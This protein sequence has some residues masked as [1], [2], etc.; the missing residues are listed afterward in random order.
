MTRALGSRI[1][2]RRTASSLDAAA[3]QHAVAPDAAA[4][5]RSYLGWMAAGGGACFLLLWLWI[6]SVP[7]AYLDP[8]YSYWL[9][10]Q[11]MLDRCDLGDV[12]ILGD[13]RAA[14]GIVPAMLPFKATNLAV[15][16]G[17]PVEAY[18][19]L[20]RA[21]ACPVRP[22]RVILSFESAHFMLWDLFWE[23]AA[24]FGFVRSEDLGT[25]RSAASLSGDHS[26]YRDQ[27][28]LLVPQ[29]LR[30]WLYV[31]RFPPLY[32]ASLLQGGVIWRW[33]TNAAALD[34]GMA[35]RGH[36]FFGTDAGSSIVAVDAH[37][38]GFNPAPVLDW[39]F[40]RMLALLAD[41]HIPVD[42]VALPMN[43]STA[44]EVPTAMRDAFSRYL[45][46]YEA[47]YPGFHILGDVMPNWPDRW[48]GD[49]FAHLNP[50][51]AHLYTT[52]LG[53]CLETRLAGAAAD[54][55][56]ALLVPNSVIAGGQP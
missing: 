24:R 56:A 46:A 31:A 55:C 6:A 20:R 34:A 48:F 37:L 14:A 15:G 33:W 4:Q 21:L 35:S 8:E 2:I 54:G 1:C 44:Q 7:L 53:Q 5:A 38:P 32:F 27:R 45:S 40:D 29:P 49:M 50:P 22:R 17:K 51:G 13:S 10:K 47:R 12:L 41:D 43:Q 39:Y 28:L 11:T 30:D 3:G 19:A 16:G 42:F 9:A 52:R 36:Y 26:M 25:L 23:R 18:A